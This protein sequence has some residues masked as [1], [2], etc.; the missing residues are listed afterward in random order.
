LHFLA[1]LL[2]VSLTAGTARARTWRVLFV[3][4]SYTYVNDLPNQLRQLALAAG[5]TLIVDSSAPGGYTFEAHS[6]DATTLQKIAAGGWDFVILQEQS[7]RPA[8]PPSQVEQEVYPFARAL[9]S[10]IHV[11]NPCAKTVFFMTWGRKYGDQSNCPFYPVICTYEGMQQRLRESYVQIADDNRALVA[12]VGMAWRACWYADSTLNLWS[13]DFSHP[14]LDGTYLAACVF[15]TTLFGQSPV[16]NTYTAGLAASRVQHY[17]QIAASVVADSASTWNIGE[18]EPRAGFGFS[19]LGNGLIQFADQSLNAQSVTWNFGDGSVSSLSSPA[20]TYTA[21]GIYTVTQVVSDGC[22]SDT[23]VQTVNVSMI[24]IEEAES[25]DILVFPNPVADMLRVHFNG[26]VVPERWALYTFEG[27][28]AMEGRF[29]GQ[30]DAVLD[31][32]A[33]PA[34]S[35]ELLFQQGDKR[36]RKSLFKQ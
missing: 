7:Q 22:A 9:D 8:F 23:S 2:I 5:D 35:Y 11:S 36:F 26:Q 33:L 1:L 15:Y 10:L 29:T 30:A 20:H 31:L 16:G 4:N 21:T 28:L 32:S 34:G 24:G 14:S 12:P 25:V 17:Q 3:G 19:A 6:T 18:F 13:S 27:R